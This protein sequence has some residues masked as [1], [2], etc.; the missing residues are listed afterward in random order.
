LEGRVSFDMLGLVFLVRFDD[1][2]CGGGSTGFLHL[3]LETTSGFLVD[4]LHGGS[5][6]K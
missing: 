2:G 5:Q 3:C 4:K 6:T 1:E